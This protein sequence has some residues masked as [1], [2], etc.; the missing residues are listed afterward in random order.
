MGKQLPKYKEIERDILNQIQSGALKTGD[1]IETENELCERYKVSRMTAR[2]ALDLLSSQGY[3]NRMP[4]RGTFVSSI[5]ISKKANFTRSFSDDM[6]SIGKAPG[7]IL[8]SY[9]IHRAAESPEAAR[10]LGLGDD[11]LVHSIIRIRTADDTI[12]ALNYTYLPVSLF[13][14]FDLRM[15]EGSLYNYISQHYD[16]DPT[17]GSRTISAV[18]PTPQQKKWLKIDDIPLLKISH[19]GHLTDGRRFEYSETY[20]IGSHFIYRYERSE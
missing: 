8:V 17:D 5:Q 10:E 2:K 19:P 1:Q 4:G 13:P 11:E 3:I 18:L 7:S 12:M 14:N 16:I 9:S 15:L 20:Y 6:R